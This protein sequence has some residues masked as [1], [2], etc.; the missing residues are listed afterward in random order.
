MERAV[1]C[2]TIEKVQTLSES[3]SKRVHGVDGHLDGRRLSPGPAPG[4]MGVDG[5]Q[6]PD[7][8]CA[9]PPG[10]PRMQQQQQYFLSVVDGSPGAWSPAVPHGAHASSRPPSTVLPLLW[11]LLLAS[12]ADTSFSYHP[13]MEDF[14]TH[15]SPDLSPYVLLA[16]GLLHSVAP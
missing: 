16:T 15:A 13:N 5:G 7:S 12:L 14:Q 8:S 11:P 6:T 9:R 3:K 1:L 10:P 2:T 4:A